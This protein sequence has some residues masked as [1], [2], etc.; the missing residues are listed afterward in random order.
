MFERKV[1]A[2]K[3]ATTEVDVF[4]ATVDESMI[5]RHKDSLVATQ[6]EKVGG[7]GG[8]YIDSRVVGTTGQMMGN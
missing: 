4:D 3:F 8:G 5:H 2:R 7:I 1:S 6:S